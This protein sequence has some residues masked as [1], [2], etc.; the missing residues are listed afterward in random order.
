[1]IDKPPHD[2][3]GVYILTIPMFLFLAWKTKLSMQVL[4]LY[5]YDD[6]LYNKYR[7]VIRSFA[8]FFVIALTLNLIYDIYRFYIAK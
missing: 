8:I 4:L 2:W 7:N 3:L 5:M 6:E 1:M